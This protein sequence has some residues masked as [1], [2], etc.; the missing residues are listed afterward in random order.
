MFNGLVVAYCGV[1][2]GIELGI[3]LRIWLGLG[4]GCWIKIGIPSTSARPPPKTS[5]IDSS[6]STTSTT[7][8]ERSGN[9]ASPSVHS[10]PASSVAAHSGRIGMTRRRM[11][12]RLS[13]MKTGNAASNRRLKFNHNP[14]I[15]TTQAQSHF[16]LL[17]L[18]L[19]RLILCKCR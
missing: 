13:K 17:C 16:L 3:W 11:N 12:L 5:H 19:A 8:S 2:V 7:T 1:W 10:T 9:L 18:C 14:N 15:H 4:A 6:G